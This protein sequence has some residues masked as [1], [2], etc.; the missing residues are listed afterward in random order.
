MPI[1]KVAKSAPISKSDF[2]ERLKSWF[3]ETDERCIGDP[4]VPK[5]S[6]WVFIVDGEQRFR[7]HADTARQGVN[8]YLALVSIHG[9]DLVW[10]IVANQRG[11]ENAAAFGPNRER[12]KLFYLYLDETL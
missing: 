12:P 6:H 7:L 11:I 10:S 4:D 8:E 9:D 5:F 1:E 3:D 2:H